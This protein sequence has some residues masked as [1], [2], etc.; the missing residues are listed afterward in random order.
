MTIDKIKKIKAEHPEWGT[1]KIAETLG[2]SRGTVRR[3]IDASKVE[4]RIN[5]GEL[6]PLEASESAKIR[7]RLRKLEVRSAWEDRAVSEI[8]AAVRSAI[9]LAG[10][11]FTSK[12]YVTPKQDGART[13]EVALLALSDTHIGKRITRETTMGLGHYD[14]DVFLHRLAHLEKQVIHLIRDELRAPISEIY[15]PLLGD[16]VEGCLNHSQEKPERDLVMDQCLFA[17]SA[18]YQ[19]IRNLSAF[20]PVRVV[21]AAVGNHGRLPSQ[22]KMPTENRYSNFDYVTMGLIEALCRETLP[23]VRFTMHR[24]PFW[25]E[26]INGWKFMFGH[27]DHLRGGDKAM[28]VP[29]HA[30]ARQINATTQRYSA[31]GERPPDYYIVGDKHR[32]IALPTA[33][34]RFL[35]NGAWFE[36][37]SYALISNFPP[38][39]PHQIFFGVHPKI[40]KSWSYDVALDLAEETHHY[41]IPG[42]LAHL[43]GGPTKKETK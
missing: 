33:T 30:I 28:G 7:D 35:V 26:E 25:V 8:S 18:L 34:G 14:P 15:I 1:R 3:A 6:D 17:G 13:P 10:K 2:L 4:N 36:D 11:I 19:F 41:H 37:D 22:K 32:P 27:G 43:V 16:I 24:S 39:R 20:R 9:P 12:P 38:A 42:H 29:S 40:G 21:A 5:D 23:N 31:R